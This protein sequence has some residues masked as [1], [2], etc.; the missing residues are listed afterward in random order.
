MGSGFR[1]ERL[2]LAK[3]VSK[4]AKPAASAP[5]YGWRWTESRWAY[6]LLL[7]VAVIAVVLAAAAL[8]VGTTGEAARIVR[9]FRCS[10]STGQ[11]VL[12]DGAELQFETPDRSQMAEVRLIDD[13][14]FGTALE[15][16]VRSR[17][18]GGDES[19]YVFRGNGTLQVRDAVGNPSY[20]LSR[21]CLGQ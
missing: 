12:R 1:C 6:V 11:C 15:M 18:I 19:A 5:R 21:D 16:R 10:P 17:E 4:S 14:S 13:G 2:G 9:V 20:T 3:M 8:A 7:T